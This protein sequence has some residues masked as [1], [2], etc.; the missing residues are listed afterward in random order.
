MKSLESSDPSHQTAYHAWASV[1]SSLRPTPRIQGLP[2]LPGCF[3]AVWKELRQWSWRK[4]PGLG[5][6]LLHGAMAR[7][8]G[9]REGFK[10]GEFGGKMG[11]TGA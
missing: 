1:H 9:L 8:L 11:K 3:W 5:C 4:G 2:A 7:G 6:L 10:G